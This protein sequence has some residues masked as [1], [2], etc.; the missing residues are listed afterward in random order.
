MS[1]NGFEKGPM[2]CDGGF[3]VFQQQNVGNGHN[4]ER[5]V[6]AFR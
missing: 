6:F 3:V 2:W 5:R 1:Q 4:V